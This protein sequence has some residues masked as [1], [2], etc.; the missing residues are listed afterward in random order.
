MPAPSIAICIKNILYPE[1]PASGLLGSN[2]L[3]TTTQK[4]QDSL[5]K[6]A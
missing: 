4:I 3:G 2:P 1:A 5:I 6:I